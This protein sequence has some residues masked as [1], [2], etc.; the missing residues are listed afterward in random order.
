MTGLLALLAEEEWIRMVE[1]LLTE[2]GLVEES[3]YLRRIRE[4]GQ[5]EGALR[6]QQH[7]ILTVLAARFLLSVPVQQEVERALTHYT[8]E[9][10]LATL[11]TTAA[12]CTGLEE[13]LSILDT[14][15]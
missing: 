11:L 7:A 4:E 1:Q 8:D 3:P 12:H 13:F 10:V 2:D 15:R 6:A 5:E 14:Q 9:S